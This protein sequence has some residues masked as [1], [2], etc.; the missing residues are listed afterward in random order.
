MFWVLGRGLRQ[1]NGK[2][3][4]WMG[5]SFRVLYSTVWGEWDTSILHTLKLEIKINT[6]AVTSDQWPQRDG[7]NHMK[8]RTLINLISLNNTFRCLSIPFKI[9]CSPLIQSLVTCGQYCS[10]Y[11]LWVNM[12]IVFFFILRASFEL[13]WTIVQLRIVQLKFFFWNRNL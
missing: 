1:Y 7:E 5:A 4:N 9:I 11:E 10:I 13:N 12:S 2:R 6:Y 3:K 8:M